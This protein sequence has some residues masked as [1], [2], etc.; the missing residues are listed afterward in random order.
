MTATITKAREFVERMRPSAGCD[1]KHCGD[2]SPCHA[3]AGCRLDT[4]LDLIEALTAPMSETEALERARVAAQAHNL[5]MP[6]YYAR[7]DGDKSDLVRAIVDALL[8]AHEPLLV[9][10]SE[11]EDAD[12]AWLRALA[13]Q[14][15]PDHSDN[16]RLKAIVARLEE[17]RHADNVWPTDDA[18][19]RTGIEYVRADLT[20]PSTPS[21][22]DV[23][24]MARAIWALPQD[25]PNEAYSLKMVM[26]W[27]TARRI[28][29]SLAAYL[30][31]GNNLP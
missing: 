20:R 8:H 17:K 10:A 29:A 2:S 4:A 26:T 1:N 22:D 6:G 16:D 3:C 28:A 12:A 31:K 7:G 21:E 13:E 11:D 27:D 23:E 19:D 9:K 30:N 18:C 5:H 25:P 14:H 15:W 24:R